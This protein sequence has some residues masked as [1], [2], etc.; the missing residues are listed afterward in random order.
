MGLAWN[1]AHRHLLASG[2][3]DCTVKIWDLDA[4]SRGGG[5]GA[6][7]HTYTHHRGKVQSV[8]WNPAEASVLAAAS[9]DR[10]ISVT[11]ARA[12]DKSRVARYSLPADPE[13]LQW[14][15]HNPAVLLAACEDGSLL[16]YDVRM[17]DAPLWRVAAA[18]GAAVT[19]LA[20]AP[21]ARGLLASGSLDKSVKLWDTLAAAPGGGGGGGGKAAGGKAAPAP[22]SAAA[23]VCV[24][25]KSMAA[26]GQVFS[27]AFFPNAPFL[28]AAGGSKGVLAVW[29]IEA[30]GGEVP[31]SAPAP[32]AD[33]D[34]GAAA[35]AAA[36]AGLLAADASPTA[37]RFAG[38]LVSDPASIPGNPLAVRAR[39]DAQAC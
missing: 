28:L 14:G 39:R 15:V 31:P 18:H 23:P 11:D 9:Y 22:A 13:A 21:L 7:L 27:V 4:T 35:A 20:Q 32:P 1:R 25:G 10:T 36:E 38:R 3:A 33:G 29:D 26:I 30:D 24:A 5:G 19:C 34:G 6:V 2:S 12:A 8:A 17:P 37:R 16:S